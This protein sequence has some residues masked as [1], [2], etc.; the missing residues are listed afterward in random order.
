MATDESE[1]I[2]DIWA[3]GV[4]DVE[5]LLLDVAIHHPMAA[6]YQ[7]RAASDVGHA[8]AT[9]AQKKLQRYPGAGGRCVTPFAVE[10]WGR[11]DAGAEH[12]LEKMAAAATRRAALRGQDFHSGVFLKRWQ[13][14]LDAVVQRGV[15]MAVMAGRTGLAG[16]RHQPRHGQRV[17]IPPSL[18]L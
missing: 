10:T 9:A 16:K 15:A 11:L 3:F 4:A 14:A 1:A 6:A 17:A 5:D 13:A 12:L 18:L 8:A 7:P 2:L